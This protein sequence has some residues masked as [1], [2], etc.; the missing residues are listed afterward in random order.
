MDTS[1]DALKLAL[2][3]GAEHAGQGHAPLHSYPLEAASDAIDDLRHGRAIL[4]PR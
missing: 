2:D 1:Q 4:M 3:C